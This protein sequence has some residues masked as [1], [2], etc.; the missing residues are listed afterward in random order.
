[1]DRHLFKV[2]D[3]LTVLCLEYAFIRGRA[4]IQGGRLIEALR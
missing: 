2:N 1:M 3:Y 4:L